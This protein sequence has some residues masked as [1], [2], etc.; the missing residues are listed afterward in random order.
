MTIYLTGDAFSVKAKRFNKMFTSILALFFLLRI[1]NKSHFYAPNKHVFDMSALETKLQLWEVQ[2]Q[3]R[4]YSHFP[5][6]QKQETKIKPENF[7]SAIQDLRQEFSSRFVDFWQYANAFKLFG[8]P[9]QTNVE[10]VEE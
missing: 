3:N 4:N 10:E 6:L 2:I 9:F 7:V 5:N 8:T 1:A